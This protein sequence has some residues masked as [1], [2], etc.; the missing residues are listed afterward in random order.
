MRIALLSSTVDIGNGYGNITVEYCRALRRKGVDVTLFL[1]TEE[2]RAAESLGWDVP[3]RFVLPRY[4]FRFSLLTI[5]P[6]LRTVDVSGFDVVHSLLDFPYCVIAARS[7]HAYGKPFMMGSQ[8]TYGVV[9]L[10]RWLDRHFLMQT[11]R[12]SKKIVVPS[13][14][15]RDAILQYAKEELPIDIIHNGVN[16]ARFSRTVDASDLRRSLGDRPLLL[17]VGGLK[18]RKGQ[19]LVI[20]ALPALKKDHPRLLYILVGD[21]HT[22]PA[23]EA[24]AREL[25]VVDMVQCVGS[26][27]GDELLRYFRACDVYV[28]TPRIHHLTFEGFGIVYLEASACGKPIV[29][30]DAGG[31]RDAVV[32][33]VTGIVVPDG[34]VPAIAA[35]IDQLLKNPAEAA[36]MGEEGKKYAAA[37]DWSIIVDKFTAFYRSLV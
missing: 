34:S 1:P 35:A 37:H 11:Y 17:T 9:P 32:D 30:T 10:T 27:T 33:A 14:F 6:Y 26:K 21:G 20:R 25:G 22:R 12:R 29:A 23:L 13:A 31:V 28:H 8:G 3:M 24:L 5:W 4:A 16:F 18:D 36:R 19:D 15:T 2:R 7:A